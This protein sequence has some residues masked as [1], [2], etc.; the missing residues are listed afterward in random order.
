[1]TKVSF[2]AYDTFIIEAYTRSGGLD[3]AYF[4]DISLSKFNKPVISIVSPALYQT[5]NIGEVVSI[6]AT[7]S[8]T[9]KVKFFVDNKLIAEDTEAPY[10]CDLA[11]VKAG[12]FLISAA[13]F[14]VFGD[15]ILTENV[16]IEVVTPNLISNGG[17]ED[18]L[19]GWVDKGGKNSILTDPALV[20]KGNK[21]LKLGPTAWSMLY[22]SVLV[23]TG[24]TYLLS[25]WGFQQAADGSE[26]RV[27]IWDKTD[28]VKYASLSFFNSPAPIQ[29]FVKVE[30]PASDTVLIEVF[31]RGGGL[32]SVYFDDI[33]LSE[34]TAPTVSLITPS[35][36][37][38]FGMDAVISINADASNASKVK[39]FANGELI[40]ETLA[41][42]YTLQ[43]NAPLDT[44][45]I[46]V[47]AFD[48]TG[49]SILS[50]SVKIIK[51][52]EKIA[53]TPISRFIATPGETSVSLKWSAATDASGIKGYIVFVNDA[54][55][56]TVSTF[57]YTSVSLNSST[58]YTFKVIALDIYDN[59]SSPVSI[60]ATTL[61]STVGIKI[62]SAVKADIYPN[63]VSSELFINSPEGIKYVSIVNLNGKTLVSKSVDGKESTMNVSNL[64]N[65]LYILKVDLVDG[66]S[67]YFKVLKK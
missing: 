33:T 58:L 47:A 44:F 3:S 26:S 11:T 2:A 10:T 42:P 48:A 13:A 54:V 16:S 29:N 31:T 40:G 8:F 14:D 51:Q 52:T 21:T 38:I 15:S 50:N 57:A 35:Q 39:F 18:G 27:Q 17:F 19:T 37:Q 62:N 12:G 67:N 59:A 24:K 23:E 20:I 43:W 30:F 1:M 32:D 41:K 9:N 66:H 4:D 63:P 55:A 22:D 56:D 65:G 49:D 34:Y 53:P 5:Y 6:S 64:E 36:D 45:E 25:A 46:S 61:Q 60:Q 7:A 28:N